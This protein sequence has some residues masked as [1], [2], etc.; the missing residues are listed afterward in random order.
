MPTPRPSFN[1][2]C[3]DKK[4][5]WKD[6]FLLFNLRDKLFKDSICKNNHYIAHRFIIPLW[7]IVFWI[8]I[9]YL[10][11]FILG[12]IIQTF[13]FTKRC[14]RKNKP[15]LISLAEKYKIDTLGKTKQQLC[16]S[17]KYKIKPLFTL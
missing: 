8:P 14:N 13:R 7:I 3:K 16:K 4:Y 9:L 1:Y 12:S 17:L 6:Y 11:L 2:Y 15:F 10:F 5:T